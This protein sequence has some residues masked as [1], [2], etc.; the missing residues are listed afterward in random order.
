MGWTGIIYRDLKIQ[1]IFFKLN[2]IL[3]KVVTMEFLH[4]FLLYKKTQKLKFLMRFHSC[5]WG[6][7]YFQKQ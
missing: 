2:Q 5:D 1:G 6:I 3:G 7:K 4:S